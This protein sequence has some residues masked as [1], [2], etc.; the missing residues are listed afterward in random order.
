MVERKDLSKEIP[1][2]WHFCNDISHS[3]RRPTVQILPE[4]KS[5]LVSPIFSYQYKD[6]SECSLLCS[7]VVNKAHFLGHLPHCVKFNE[8]DIT[9]DILVDV[10]G[11]DI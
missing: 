8:A 2:G 10:I 9:P 7:D 6:L 5:T 11:P 1:L 4:S 3:C